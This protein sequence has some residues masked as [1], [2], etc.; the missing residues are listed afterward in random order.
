[1]AIKDADKKEHYQKGLTLVHGNMEFVEG[2]GLCQL[3]NLLFQIF[4]N[5]PLAIVERHTHRVKDFPDPMKET[6]KGIDATIAE[7][8]LDLKVKNNTTSTFQIC[9]TF[10]EEY[11]YGK[12]LCNESNINTFCIKNK[13]L[14]YFK[15]EQKIYEQVDIYREEIQNG[16]IIKEEKLYTNITQIGYPLP[17]TVK[18]IEKED[19]KNE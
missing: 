3:S 17:D 1:M 15:K 7:G 4:L 18:I 19:F 2:G 6:L 10:D 16:V 12:L 9:I 14:Q 13:N 11:I 5:S 8:F